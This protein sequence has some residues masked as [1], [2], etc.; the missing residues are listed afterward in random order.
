MCILDPLVAQLPYILEG[1]RP[2]LPVAAAEPDN[3]C[4]QLFHKPSTLQLDN[5]YRVDNIRALVT[6][7]AGRQYVGQFK[8]TLNKYVIADAGVLD[9]DTGGSEDDR[10]ALNQ[11]M[12]RCSEMLYN[13]TKTNTHSME[14]YGRHHVQGVYVFLDWGS[15]EIPAF[16]WLK[17]KLSKWVYRNAD[18][19][20]IQLADLELDVPV[21]LAA[22]DQRIG[23]MSPGS[24]LDVSDNML[25]RDFWSRVNANELEIFERTQQ[26]LASTL[27]QNIKTQ[28]GTLLVGGCVERFSVDHVKLETL[29]IIEAGENR[30]PSKRNRK[31]QI[32]DMLHSVFASPA[33]Q[34][35]LWADNGVPVGASKK[36]MHAY[37]QYMEQKLLN[38]DDGLDSLLKFKAQDFTYFSGVVPDDDTMLPGF[39]HYAI[40]RMLTATQTLDEFSPLHD[41][42]ARQKISIHTADSASKRT[43]I[44]IL[45]F[46][47]KAITDQLATASSS[48]MQDY[49]R[50][51]LSL[52]D[53]SYD[54]Q[55]ETRAQDTDPELAAVFS[56]DS[57]TPA[58]NAAQESCIFDKHDLHSLE[59]QA[60][61]SAF[62][63][64]PHVS[65]QIAS[66]T[67]I[68]NMCTVTGDVKRFGHTH[69]G[70]GI[71]SHSYGTPHGGRCTLRDL[72][73]HGT[74]TPFSTRDYASVDT[75][76]DTK[77]TTESTHAGDKQCFD[78]QDD[79][80]PVSNPPVVDTTHLAGAIY[81]GLPYMP[82][83]KREVVQKA[84][85]V[86]IRIDSACVTD[87]DATKTASLFG[88]DDMPNPHP[89]HVRY[90]SLDQN[91]YNQVNGRMWK[92]TP[93][94]DKER[95]RSDHKLTSAHLP[96][97]L[98]DQDLDF[99]QMLHNAPEP[100]L[101]RSPAAP[102]SP[103]TCGIQQVRWS[104]GL[105]VSVYTLN[106]A[107]LPK[108]QF[109]HVIYNDRVLMRR[110]YTDNTEQQLFG[111]H[112]VGGEHS[113]DRFQQITTPTPLFSHCPGMLAVDPYAETKLHYFR[114][115]QSSHGKDRMHERFH[116]F[117]QEIWLNKNMERTSESLTEIG[118]S[119]YTY[120][121]GRLWTADCEKSN[122]WFG[123]SWFFS[124][125][126]DSYRA[127]SGIFL[128][129][130]KT[131]FRW[132]TQNSFPPRSIP[133]APYV[134]GPYD[135]SVT[136]GP[137]FENEFKPAG[138]VG[139][140]KAS[141]EGHSR[142][143]SRGYSGVA[144]NARNARTDKP[145]CFDWDVRNEA[146]VAHRAALTASSVQLQALPCQSTP[147][148]T[149]CP[150]T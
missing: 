22:F 77:F 6:Y 25:I 55:P 15:Y 104:N 110:K 108:A 118:T 135:D 54:E 128:M 38:S 137:F 140:S 122:F 74:H 81:S 30:H 136:R 35:P 126:S 68:H 65:L 127:R 91:T 87:L 45:R 42:S 67:H 119:G 80:P 105:Q 64:G 107:S 111:H 21:R 130:F 134:H 79:A 132:T 11:K 139:Y 29:R 120:D 75:L 144:S 73:V 44:K 101:Y 90:R 143:Y 115:V 106:T 5:G 19:R 78:R 70:P 117:N 53:R 2:M 71:E 114:T 1:L 131:T 149:D 133:S 52:F 129:F 66:T 17:M 61:F 96:D 142:G 39:V 46:D 7:S 99:W 57:V 138:S 150:V 34:T 27:S 76:Q 102:A 125:S 82:V 98:Y 63:V 3:V 18:S 83:G 50:N 123:D 84:D 146:L 121:Q 85:G 112:F 95:F 56:R 10:R 13:F 36:K 12:I 59:Q 33:G 4:L 23:V 60:A 20:A 124:K 28:D 26:L 32:E 94:G 14:M 113:R 141:M 147:T 97:A 69:P 58:T 116:R 41:A 51:Y 62:G 31:Y 72:D 37:G 103:G 93:T 88:L 92:N 86:C 8:E 109:S 100:E 43:G 24:P 48:R 148:G 89:V 145:D 16:W 40:T 47:V 49:M 9:F